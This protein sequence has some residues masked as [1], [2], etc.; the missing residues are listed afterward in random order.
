MD[1]HNW[2]YRRF[3]GVTAGRRGRIHHNRLG[4]AI[5]V[6]CSIVAFPLIADA[7]GIVTGKVSFA[8]KVPAAKE[9]TFGKFPNP[10]YCA[11]NQNKS[12]DGKVRLLKEVQIAKG[13]GLQDAIVAV[14]DIED[15][16]WMKGYEGTKVHAELCEWSEFTGVA[17]N[18]GRFIVENNDAD[19]DDPK[20][21]AGVLHNPHAFEVK[22]PSALT[23]FN[24]GL[25]KKGDSLDKKIILRKVKAGSVVRL[26]CDQHEYMQAWFLPVKNQHFV[27]VKEDGTF[28]LKDVP[29]GKHKLIAWH[30]IAGQIEKEIE[31]K[32][33]GSVKADFEI[34]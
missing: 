28:E 17:V 19:P 22:K 23:L 2:Q 15:E 18:K 14:R 20:S 12:D 9:F 29:A 33:G 4:V 7:G 32:D 5:V 26:Q 30:P 27:K 25:A 13:G 8:G 6:A 10:G 16:A 34:K 1:L 31:V 3:R 21:V 24:I 11:K